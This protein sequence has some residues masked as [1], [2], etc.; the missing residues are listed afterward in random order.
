MKSSL[1]D[2]LWIAE[3][4]PLGTAGVI[5]LTLCPGKKGSDSLSMQ[6]R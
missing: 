1:S 3:V 6:I 2:P 5:G 4:S